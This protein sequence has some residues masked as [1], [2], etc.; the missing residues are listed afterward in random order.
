MVLFQL[1]DCKTVKL[2]NPLAYVDNGTGGKCTAIKAP[3]LTCAWGSPAP[4]ATLNEVALG[5]V[6]FE[7]G[8]S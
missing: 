6:K 2:G 5:P 3:N 4:L 7:T 8:S 1:S